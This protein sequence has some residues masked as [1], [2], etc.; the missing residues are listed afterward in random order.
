MNPIAKTGLRLLIITVVLTGCTFIYSIFESRPPKVISYFIL[1][2]IFSILLGVVTLLIGRLIK[3]SQH[4]FIRDPF[5]I[6]L[7]FILVIGISKIL[8]AYTADS[9]LT[10][11][12][13]SDNG[14]KEESKIQ[15]FVNEE[16]GV[17]F[18]YPSNWTPR[19]AQRQSTLILLYEDL[20]TKAT[21]NLS[22]VTQDQEQI[23]NYN[24]DYFRTNLSKIHKTIDS[25]NTQFTTI[26]DKTI[27]WTTYDADVQT[28]EGLL[29][30]RFI[31][32]TTLHKGKRFMLIV[33]VPKDN[34][35]QIEYDVQTITK[36]LQ[37]K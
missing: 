23:E 16:Y 10:E 12:S 5:K 35:D 28:N 31:T 37:L 9:Q 17:S 13:Y 34:A 14:S 30:T 32:L 19:T 8:G 2:F 15:S 21:C 22:M 3:S 18:D 25:L 7:T 11:T 24:N 26:N 20:G 1:T 27:S 29:K 6:I 36:S 4:A 33:T